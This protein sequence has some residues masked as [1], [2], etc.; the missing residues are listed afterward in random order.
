[1][2][3]QVRWKYPEH[4]PR[5]NG[6]LSDLRYYLS[7]TWDW[8]LEKIVGYGYKPFRA[9]FLLCLSI[10]T[11]LFVY[12]QAAN[13]GVMTPTH[14]LVYLNEDMPPQCREN[15][16]YSTS[17]NGS[18]LHGR[19]AA[20]VHAVQPTDL[21]H[22]RRHTAGGVQAGSRLESALNRAYGATDAFGKSVRAFQYFQIIS[23]WVLSLLF[24]S[25]VSGIIR[26]D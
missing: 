7:H 20:G 8:C 25:A 5:P 3:R 1:L 10:F 18:G 22:R 2:Q 13:H 24:V 19:D 21:F 15:W 26:K 17:S 9:F 4:Y 6:E 12:W 14:P 11:G 16:V 23:G